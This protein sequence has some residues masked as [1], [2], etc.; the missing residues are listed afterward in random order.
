MT[1]FTDRLLRIRKRGDQRI[2]GELVDL[3]NDTSID[4]NTF[5]RP[6]KNLQ[7]CKD[8]CT[9]TTKLLIEDD[10]FDSFLVSDETT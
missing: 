4:M 7:D 1:G 3:I 10:E 8:V 5:Q 2:A 9:R 6:I